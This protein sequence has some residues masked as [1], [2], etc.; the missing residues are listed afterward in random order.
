MG[1][2][3]S[4]LYREKD[5][6]PHGRPFL[7]LKP[8]GSTEASAARSGK[9]DHR[10]RPRLCPTWSADFEQRNNGVL[11]KGEDKAAGRLGGRRR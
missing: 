10:E 7:L 3:K 1:A 2:K 5:P 9:T 8:P 4:E 6:S 11:K